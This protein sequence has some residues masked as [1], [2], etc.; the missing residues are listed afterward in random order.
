MYG[1]ILGAGVISVIATC[2]GSLFHHVF[3]RT[4]EQIRVAAVHTEP[5]R[6]RR[7]ADLDRTRML[8]PVEG[9]GEATTHRG[10]PVDGFGEATTHGTRVRG[11]KR[12]A[13]AA[14]LVF[15]V[16]MGGITAYELVSEEDFGGTKGAT[17]FGS[18]V[19]GGGSGSGGGADGGGRNEPSTDGTPTREP[20]AEPQREQGEQ[21]SDG[22][23]P[24][25]D[26]GRNTPDPE[27]TPSGSTGGDPTPTP[28]PPPST[29]APTPTPTATPNPTG[30][31][32]TDTGG[33]QTP[34]A[35]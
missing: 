27:P 7:D 19:R 11:W 8:A 12:S 34:P 35:E 30:T 15:L 22:V 16:S 28:T 3:K 4:G 17:T 13:V 31:P 32:S 5:P 9:S 18:A 25:P 21:G 1:T 24:S 26:T 29:G 23:T 20:G 14:A 6:A 10:A 2:G 33:E